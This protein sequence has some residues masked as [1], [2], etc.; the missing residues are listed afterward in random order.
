M[1]TQDGWHDWLSKVVA[2]RVHELVSTPGARV[3][4]QDQWRAA[5]DEG[6]AHDVPEA[7]A[8]LVPTGMLPERYALLGAIHDERCEKCD[9]ID[10][11]NTADGWDR[12][13]QSERRGAVRYTVLCGRVGELTE[14]DRGAIE[15][16]LQAVEED[17]RDIG[18]ESGTAPGDRVGAGE[19]NTL[20]INKPGKQ[21]STGEASP[22]QGPV[23]KRA[24]TAG[25]QYRWTVEAMGGGQ[26]TDREVYDQLEKVLT[27]AGEQAALPTFETWQRNL[28]E[29]RKHTGTQKNQPRGG[30]AAAARSVV[31]S[32]DT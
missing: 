2:G 20:I 31:S 23:P 12:D 7:G 21:C 3:R 13:Y 14:N 26:F 8:R 5:A 19:M 4:F 10:P 29:Y 16:A 30:R 24:H 17:L 27:N 15:R 22:L 32:G 28:R 11:W 9:R 18:K 25:E 1:V 6:A